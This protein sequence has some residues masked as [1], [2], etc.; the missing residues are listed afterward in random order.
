M[1]PVTHGE[2]ETRRQILL[3]SL[4]L[5]PST[6]A[7]APLAGLGAALLGAGRCSA[8]RSCWEPGGCS[9]RARA[10]HAVR[11]FRFSILYLF[12]LFRVPVGGRA[13]TLTGWP[14]DE[15]ARHRL[16]PVRAIRVYTAR[17]SVPEIEPSGRPSGR[18]AAG[19]RAG[20][21]VSALGGLIVSTG[22]G[23][24]LGVAVAAALLAA[25][26]RLPV[27]DW[28]AG[29]QVY[30]TC[31]PC[32]GANGVGNRALGAPAIA[33]LPKWY[34]AAE[35]NKFQHDIRGAHPRDSEG[36]RMRPMART[37]YH[38]GDV[39]SVAEYVATI[40]PLR[41]RRRRWRPATPRPGR[42]ATPPSCITCHGPDGSGNE[43]LGA[44]PLT[45]QRDWYMLA[46]LGKFKTR[47]ARC[48]PRGRDRRA[49]GGHVADAPGHDRDARRDRLHS[50][51]C[52]RDTE[53]AD[54]G[55]AGRRA[56]DDWARH[57][58]QW[59]FI[60]SLLGCACCSS[61]AVFIF[62]SLSGGDPR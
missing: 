35:L 17:M 11:L 61:A 56:D 46:Q 18:R 4:A 16:D 49:D 12:V 14:G 37:L 7:V 33:G 27:R 36:A 23:L 26:A 31:V 52:S 42:R 40:P 28:R 30:E 54:H 62:I 41:A 53:E 3:Y 47:H 59:T 29:K 34:L 57:G 22:C 44:P 6:L 21:A 58:R 9:E 39:E 8:P 1:L 20:S 43:A 51:R 13:G 25:A 55:R 32:H 5:V 45:R 38:P 60:W 48:A 15:P 50:R 2:A 19:N 24:A 10:A